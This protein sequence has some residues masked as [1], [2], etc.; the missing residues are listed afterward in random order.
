MLAVPQG[1]ACFIHVHGRHVAVGIRLDYNFHWRP[2]L[3][4]VFTS[5]N[6]QRG[7]WVVLLNKGQNLPIAFVYDCAAAHEPTRNHD[8][9]APGP[10][11]VFASTDLDACPKGQDRTI[12]GHYHIWESTSLVDLL[13]I[14]LRLAQ[15]RLDLAFRWMSRGGH[16]SLFARPSL[17][18]RCR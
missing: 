6:S 7:R 16:G 18:S 8:F 5:A 15:E 4:M 12:N 2:G 10:A 1:N 17:R 13:H 9:G 14:K 3:A 11:A